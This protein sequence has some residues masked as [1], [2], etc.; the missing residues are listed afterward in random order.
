MV[1]DKN[2]NSSLVSILIPGARDKYIICN[3]LFYQI[4]GIG[5]FKIYKP[6][7]NTTS[8]KL[9]TTKEKTHKTLNWNIIIFVRFYFNQR[10]IHRLKA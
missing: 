5:E 7:I 10:Y 1:S 6:F 8:D 4:I 3:N 2:L 9:T